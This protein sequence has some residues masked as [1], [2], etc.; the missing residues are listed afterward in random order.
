MGAAPGR[1]F[2][3]NIPAMRLTTR[4]SKT[5]N[6][7]GVAHMPLSLEAGHYDGDTAST[8]GGNKVLRISQG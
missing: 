2:A 4:P 7:E 8:D 6:I 5:E 3:G 1:I